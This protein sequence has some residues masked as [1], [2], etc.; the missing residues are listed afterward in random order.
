MYW[1]ETFMPYWRTYYHL[2]WATKQR[3]PTIDERVEALL[4]RSFL[5]T[6]QDLACHL[7]ATGFMPDH[8]HVALSIPPSMPVSQVVRQLKGA[9]SFAVNKD[10]NAAKFAWQQGYGVV[11]FSESNL[12]RVVDYLQNQRAHHGEESLIGRLEKV[13]P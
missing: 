2:I 3:Q 11:T 13:E 12:Q 1:D 8:V 7:I 6:T 4:V 5:L 9:S 10:G